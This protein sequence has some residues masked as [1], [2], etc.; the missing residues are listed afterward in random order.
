MTEY[1]DEPY[2]KAYYDSAKDLDDPIEMEIKNE[3]VTC[4]QTRQER[5]PMLHKVVEQFTHQL[6]GWQFLCQISGQDGYQKR[7]EQHGR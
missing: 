4:R 7:I 6:Q 5:M 3:T 1:D 2:W